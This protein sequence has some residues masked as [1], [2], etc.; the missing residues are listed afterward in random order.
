MRLFKK[1]REAETK[2]AQFETVLERLIAAQSG[3]LSG[4]VSPQNCMRSPTVHSIVT[5]VSRRIAMTPLHVYQK[6]QSNGR[7]VK[8]VL[9]IHPV[10][11]LLRKPNSWQT[12]YEF[13][14][15]AASTF[16]R[17]G[18]FYSH[19]GRGQTGPIRQLTPIDPARVTPEQ[20]EN[21]NVRYR[22]SY[23]DGE[24]DYLPPERMFNARGPAR[25]FL[26]GDSPV[27]DVATA[28]AL[29]IMAE[30]FGATFFQNGALPLLIFKFMQGSAG[31]KK[32]EEAQAF[33]EAFQEALGGSNRHR[34]MLLP[35]GIEIDDPVA[36]E[37]DKAQ[38][39][40]TRKYQRTVIAGAFGV[41]PT[42]TG[43]L[44]RATWNNVEQM[45]QD[46][47]S[48][49]VM[50]VTSAFEQAMERDLLTD[51]DRRGGICIR[52]NL[53]ALLRADFKSRQEGLQIQREAGVI[54]AN[55]WREHEGYNPI[56]GE[57]GEAYITP[58]NF[59]TQEQREQSTEDNTDETPSDDQA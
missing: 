31:F 22:V 46:F 34:A 44:E 16:M 45:D 48:N 4:T 29:E 30:E 9:P 2:K 40:E 10:A 5:A 32:K 41:P 26:E 15:D 59:A 28:I 23:S 42:F 8:E 51:E 33:I 24:I 14:Q 50:P 55:E 35:K 13:W 47:I 6:S 37:H 36:I 53:D 18:R 56:S 7:D 27:T 38:F 54:N 3:S 19:K 57:D 52:F 17:W 12:P 11:R 58:L 20:D 1:R 21:Y 49:V 43:D 39:I 25:D